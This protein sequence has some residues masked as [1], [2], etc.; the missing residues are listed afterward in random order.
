MRN[1][2]VEH[3]PYPSAVTRRDERLQVARLSKVGVD[4]ANVFLPVAV[5][6]FVRLLGNRGDPYRIH[7]E[8]LDVVQLVDESLESTAAVVRDVGA[9]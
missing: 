7:A 6:T 2:H 4:I 1:L 8:P 9:G 3:D 5:K